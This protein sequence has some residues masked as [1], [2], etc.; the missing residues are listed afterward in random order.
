MDTSRGHVEQFL[1]SATIPSGYLRVVIVLCLLAAI[2][3][4]R[5]KTGDGSKEPPSLK[6]PIPMISDTYQYMT[7]MHGFLER[8]A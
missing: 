7:D 6:G 2:L 1:S 3:V 8:V 5:W 4:P